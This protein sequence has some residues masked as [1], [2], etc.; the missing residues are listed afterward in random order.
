MPSPNDTDGAQPRRRN[1]AADS[2]AFRTSPGRKG[3]WT[4][5]SVAPALRSTMAANDSTETARPEATFQVPLGPPGS[6]S[7]RAPPRHPGRG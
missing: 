2:A 4:R 1:R 5:P 3:R 6:P 7:P